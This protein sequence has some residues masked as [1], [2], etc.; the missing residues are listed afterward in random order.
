MTIRSLAAW[1]ALAGLTCLALPTYA[2]TLQEQVAAMTLPAPGVH[3]RVLFTREELPKIRARAVT[4]N[5]KVA[6]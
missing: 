2:A 4:V 6:V 5:G 3:P 1:L